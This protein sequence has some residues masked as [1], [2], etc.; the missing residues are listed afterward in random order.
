VLDFNLQAGPGVHWFVRDDLA[1]TVEARYFH[2]SAASINHPNH[3]LN[4]VIGVVGLIWF[5]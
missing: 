4:G 1:V 2:L 3:G 5:F